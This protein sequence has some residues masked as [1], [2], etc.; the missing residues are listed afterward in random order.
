MEQRVKAL[1]QFIEKNGGVW[2]VSRRLGYA[3]ASFLSQMVG[4]KKN[5]P[6]TE[7]TLKKIE[8]EYSMEP[9]YFDRE[10]SEE[11]APKFQSIDLAKKFKD[12]GIEIPISKYLDVVSFIEKHSAGRDSQSAF[13]DDLVDLF[14]QS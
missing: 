4:P 11:D 2:Q 1:R 6:I 10:V 3:N 12:A 13:V 8:S 7:K 9:G 5:R 14:R